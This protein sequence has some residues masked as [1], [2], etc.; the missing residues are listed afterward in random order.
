M[1]TP[2]A[3]TVCEH[4]EIDAKSKLHCI[5]SPNIPKTG[6]TNTV[7]E[8]RLKYK[9]LN[10]QSIIKRLNKKEY[11]FGGW[12][13]APTSCGVFRKSAIQPFLTFMKHDNWRTSPDKLLFN[14]LHLVG[15]ST[16]IYKPLV[17]YRRHGMNAGQCNYV[18]GDKRYNSDAARD[19]YLKN[20]IN[21]YKDILEFFKLNKKKLIKIFSKRHYN[22]MKREIYF[23]IPK[24]I[25]Y[26]LMH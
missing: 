21:L 2:C 17:L 16:K 10:V 25:I 3:L 13:W 5:N 12:W 14:F 24:L 6:A 22:A 4:M 20:Q 1:F 26:K 8:L 23:S 19:K 15:G 7:D 9:N 11:F 18:I